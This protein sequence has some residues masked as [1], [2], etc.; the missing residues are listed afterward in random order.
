[1]IGRFNCN[2]SER[3]GIVSQPEVH[4]QHDI[5]QKGAAGKSNDT[6]SPAQFWNSV[7]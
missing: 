4:A 1:M 5:Q 3:M 2:I 6:E 7:L